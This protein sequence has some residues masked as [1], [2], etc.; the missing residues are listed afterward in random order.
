MNSFISLSRKFAA[1][2]MASLAILISGAYAA[3]PVVP[4][5]G[6]VEI[7][8][9]DEKNQKFSGNWYLHQGVNEKGMVLRNGSSGEKFSMPVGNYYLEAQRKDALH[10]YYFLM[11]K[12][13]QTLPGGESILFEIQYFPTEE[14][15]DAAEKNYTEGQSVSAPTP[16]PAPAPAPAP[17]P[18]PAPAPAPTPTVKKAP[19]TEKAPV[20]APT[21]SKTTETAK[22]AVKKDTTSRTY[23]GPRVILRPQVTE[24]QPAETAADETKK[25]LELAATG[26]PGVLLLMT[27]S[28]LIGGV[29]TRKKI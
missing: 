13:P 18:A 22:K 14:A 17:I 21:E 23:L 7:R 10:P 5:T 19:I 27:I 26:A 12:N 8:V 6:N 29:V 25:P 3:A 16:N 15:R 11:S 4:D 9:I 1:S 24:N 20:S 28:G 2:L